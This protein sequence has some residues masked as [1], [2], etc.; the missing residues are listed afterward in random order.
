MKEAKQKKKKSLDLEEEKTEELLDLEE[1]FLDSS[2]E[3]VDEEGGIEDGEEGFG[4]R[5][6]RLFG[7]Y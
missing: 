7:V 1:D 5:R 3:G 6:R 2:E 4:F